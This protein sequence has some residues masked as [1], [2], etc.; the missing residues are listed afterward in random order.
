MKGSPVRVRA[1]ASLNQSV[2][3]S[4]GRARRGR[5]VTPGSL[6]PVGIFVVFPSEPAE[7]GSVDGFGRTGNG[8]STA[9]L[10]RLAEA[11]WVSLGTTGCRST[12][13]SCWCRHVA[14][15]SAEVYRV[16]D[17]RFVGYWCLTN[18]AWL[19][20]QITEDQVAVATTLAS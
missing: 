16:Q 3:A 9:L 6:L 1:S 19:I 14:A 15:E 20:R 10:Y 4:P 5:W 12:R 17:E 7:V 18:V 2:C 13:S 8:L 11:L